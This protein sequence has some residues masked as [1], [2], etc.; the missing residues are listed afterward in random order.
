MTIF[1]MTM[2]NLLAT[3]VVASILVSVQ[4]IAT[5]IEW[6]TLQYII[7]YIQH[8]TH[9]KQKVPNGPFSHS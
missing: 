6:I 5:N 2:S 4:C 8:S 7:W 3:D 9:Y 1:N